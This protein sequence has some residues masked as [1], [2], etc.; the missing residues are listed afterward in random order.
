MQLNNYAQKKKKRRTNK[1]RLWKSGALF[2]I[3][4]FSE[5]F[6]A[7]V[8]C[9]AKLSGCSLWNPSVDYSSKLCKHYIIFSCLSPSIISSVTKPSSHNKITSCFF[10]LFQL[11][12]KLN[13]VAMSPCPAGSCPGTPCPLV[14]LACESNGPRWRMMKQ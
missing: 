3:W 10:S 14:V 2:L 4:F 9:Q 13:L 11:G 5:S 12:L 1:G 8:S 7:S 6:T